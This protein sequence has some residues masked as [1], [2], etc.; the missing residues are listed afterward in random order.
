M[1][2]RYTRNGLPVRE[3]FLQRFLEMIP[4][5]LSWGTLLGLLVLSV[6]APGGSVTAV[7]FGITKPVYD[8][9]FRSSTRLTIS[10]RSFGSK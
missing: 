8:G 1:D 2:F 10:S 7:S 3:R 5:I 6:I 9:S 4:G